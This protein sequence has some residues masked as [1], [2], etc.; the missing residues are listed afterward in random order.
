[1][2]RMVRGRMIAQWRIRMGKITTTT[3]TLNSSNCLRCWKWVPGFRFDMPARCG[4]EYA[5]FEWGRIHIPVDK[6][7]IGSYFVVDIFSI[8][9]RSC[10]AISM[11]THA[12]TQTPNDERRQNAKTEITKIQ[13]HVR[14][15]SP[16]ML[17]VFVCV[18]CV[19]ANAYINSMV[20]FSI[21]Y[22]QINCLSIPIVMWGCEFSIYCFSLSLLAHW[23]RP[24]W[25]LCALCEKNLK[26]T[27]L[28]RDTGW[29][30]FMKYLWIH[31]CCRQR[32]RH[33]EKRRQANGKEWK[34]DRRHKNSYEGYVEIMHRLSFDYVAWVGCRDML[35]VLFPLEKQ[36]QHIFPFF[37]H[38]LSKK[39][40]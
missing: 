5:V 35:R 6:H 26:T 8:G 24:H 19:I 20:G 34:S 11:Q 7:G 31:R 22:M 32:V 3:H 2:W 9:A 17:L 38:I 14:L 15:R 40:A 29:L 25:M 30:R 27:M 28:Q 36:L 33:P 13:L 21:L 1:M 12:G 4:W 18:T 37:Y 23:K 16:I 39:K 10:S